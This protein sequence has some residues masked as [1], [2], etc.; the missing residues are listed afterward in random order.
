MVTVPAAAGR[1]IA[2]Q[3]V[4]AASSGIRMLKPLRGVFAA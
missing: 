4:A 2:S 1:A 3:V